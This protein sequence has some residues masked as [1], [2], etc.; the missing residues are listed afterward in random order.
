MFKCNIF[1]LP[2]DLFISQAN[3]VKPTC[4]GN[5]SSCVVALYPNICPTWTKVLTFLAASILFLIRF[6]RAWILCSAFSKLTSHNDSSTS[7]WPGATEVLPVFWIAAAILQSNVL[8][9]EIKYYPITFY[10]D[11]IGDNNI[12]YVQGTMNDVLEL[13]IIQNIFRLPL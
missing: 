10:I 1:Y 9:C 6:L 8:L 11:S 4:T 12:C 3:F 7:G 13:P 2:F 5:V